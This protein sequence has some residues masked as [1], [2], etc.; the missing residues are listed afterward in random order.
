VAIGQLK[1]LSRSETLGSII[2]L[3]NQK[4]GCGKSSTCFH[5]AGAF[6]QMGLRVL[7]IAT[8]TFENAMQL[9]H[10]SYFSHP[11]RLYAGGIEVWKL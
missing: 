3:I 8:L 2:C 11:S 7:L 6:A 9:S 1:R 5:L 4:G 10:V